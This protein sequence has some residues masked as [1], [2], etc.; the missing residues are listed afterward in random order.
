MYSAIGKSVVW[1]GSSYQVDGM[2][3]AARVGLGSGLA[4]LLIIG[5]QS[6]YINTKELTLD[7]QPEPAQD[8]KH[9][10]PSSA[11]RISITGTI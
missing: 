10:W 2:A 4:A 6:K 7:Q 5:G 9:D 3:P 11:R 1:Q 8:Q